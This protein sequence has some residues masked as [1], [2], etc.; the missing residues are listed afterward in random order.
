MSNQLD[1]TMDQGS[2]LK[3]TFTLQTGGATSFDLTG[4][5]ARLQVRKN[6]GST[7]TEING[8]LMNGKLVFVNASAGIL[9]LN[10][11]PTDTSAIKF[12]DKDDESLEMVYDLEV[13]SP[14]GKVYKP[15]RGTF[16]LNREV[17]R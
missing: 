3:Y 6:Y 14:A 12:L 11:L 10:L 16:T 1:I 7:V 15:A 9:E 5:D 2:S 13:A 8:T 17:T 4:Y